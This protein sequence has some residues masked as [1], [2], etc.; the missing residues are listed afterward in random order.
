MCALGAG[1]AAAPVP[2]YEWAPLRAGAASRLYYL[3][4]VLAAAVAPRP[5][6]TT[7]EAIAAAQT[8]EAA[9]VEAA[10]AEAAA[11]A[12]ADAAEGE[13]DGEENEDEAADGAMDVD[14]APAKS[15]PPPAAAAA[16]PASA[17]PAAADEAAP[18]ETA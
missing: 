18:M 5:H 10:A 14:D 1:W 6:L 8:R 15:A 17:A 2:Y 3:Q 4:E 9:R 16:A 7:A 11:E 13:G 12:A